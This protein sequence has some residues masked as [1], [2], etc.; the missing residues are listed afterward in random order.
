MGLASSKGDKNEA[1]RLCKARRRF[2][3]Q[4]MD[5]RYGLAAAHVSYIQSLKNIGIA[6]RR[7]AEAEVL[8]E[9]SLST[10]SAT[11][12]EKTP[13]HSSYP[14]PSPS[15]V[16][17]VS[18]SPLHN[19]ESP[20][21]KN[22]D[23]SFSYMRTAK[24]E[25]VTV[26]VNT[27]DGVS[28]YVEDEALEGAMP[29]PP[30]PPPPYFESGTWDYFDTNGQCDSFRFVGMNDGFQL[31]SEEVLQSKNGGVIDDVIQRKGKWAKVGSDNTSENGEGSVRP[32]LG[33]KDFEMAKST[34]AQQN[35]SDRTVE[36]S[37]GNGNPVNSWEVEVRPGH[38]ERN[39]N[40]GNVALELSSSKREKTAGEKD[41]CAERED[42]SE[43]ITHRAKD[44]LSSIKDI[45]HRFFRA[46]ESGREVSR[47][48]E[49]N[50]IRV[51]FSE[52]KGNRFCSANC[53]TSCFGKCGYVFFCIICLIGLPCAFSSLSCREFI[54]FRCFGSFPT[55]L[56]QR[57]SCTSFSW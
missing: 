53:I 18:D 57:K 56:L 19:E 11:E 22:S 1:L 55:C 20:S 38:M 44:F 24:A 32:E 6:L 54:C 2:I 9:S 14:S 7:Y 51:G 5:S 31:E 50:K 15:H 12:L 30:P 13:S 23:M 35:A 34:V 52:I 49:S 29:P 41:V 4:A 28:G 25:A 33:L 10:T 3:K 8:I 43:F 21:P 42:P 39:A 37:V 17:E 40:V 45:E 47:M 16:N 46:S 26:R 48:L 27:N 36:C